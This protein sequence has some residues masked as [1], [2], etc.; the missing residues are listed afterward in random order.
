MNNTNSCVAE[1]QIYDKELNKAGID[2]QSLINSLY[3]CSTAY[4]YNEQ[5]IKQN[6]NLNSEIVIDNPEF[7]NSSKEELFK[8]TFVCHL[9]P[10]NYYKSKLESK[11]M[12][13]S[14][15]MVIKSYKKSYHK[16]HVCDNCKQTVKIVV[17]SNN[18]KF[19]IYLVLNCILIFTF[20]LIGLIKKDQLFDMLFNL[21]GAVIFIIAVFYL[22]PAI[23]YE[24]IIKSPFFTASIVKIDADLHTLT[25]KGHKMV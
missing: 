10:K 18:E 7:E 13:L 22:L 3:Y 1:C 11:E 2:R 25:N 15:N 23:Y 24:K 16:E 14:Q 20:I 4:L 5:N 17:N 21:L 8:A 6:F 9:N 19:K 12:I